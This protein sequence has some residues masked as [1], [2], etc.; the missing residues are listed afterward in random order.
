MQTVSWYVKRL[1]AMSADE[2]AWRARSAA[3]DLTDRARIPLKLY[4]SV[5]LTVSEARGPA[6]LQLCAVPTGAWLSLAPG[7]PAVQWRARLTARAD[8][9]ATHRLSWFDLHDV[10]LGDPIDWNRE[11]ACGRSTPKTL[12]QSIDY[13]DFTVTGDAKVSW[14]PSRHHQLVV[15]GRA[16]RATGRREYASAVVE[17][18]DSW[19]AQCPFGYGMQWRSPLELAIRVINWTWAIDL[20]ADSGALNEAFQTR[21]MQSVMLHVWD[22]ARKYSRGSSANNHRIG[23][24]CGVFAAASYFPTLPG[25]AAL[26]DE[27]FA[28]LS[29]EIGAQ[30]YESGAT[31]EQVIAERLFA[32]QFFLAAGVVARRSGRDFAPAYWSRL[33]RMFAFVRALAEGG[34]PPLSGDGD[35]GYVLDLGDSVSDLESV[36][37][38]ETAL[39]GGEAVSGHAP[40][41]ESVY[42]LLGDSNGLGVSNVARLPAARALES[43]AFADAGYYLLQWG[44]PD[45][46]DRVSVV[47]DCGELGFGSLAAHGHADALSVMVR[48]GGVDLLVDPGTYDYFSFPAWRQ[49]FRSTRAHNTVTIDGRDQSDQ[50]GS[51]LWGRRANARC[52]AWKPRDG[53]GRVDGEHDGYAGLADTV[54]CRR[55]IDLDRDS[56]TLTITDEI[57]ARDIHEIALHFH[58]ADHCEARADGADSHLVDIRFRAGRARLRLDPSLMVTLTKGADA[59]EGGWMS[60]GYHRRTPATIVSGTI[61][62]KGPITLKTRLEFVE[63]RD[64][65]RQA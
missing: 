22:I 50:L 63:L 4:P 39:F 62:S 59:P 20:I 1:Q 53:G 6:P 26:R 49:Y 34:P 60:R 13:R 38:M 3:R 24:A 58:L 11:F 51:F 21:L 29:A 14:E 35:D 30:T 31:R 33:Q 17:Q 54:T 37:Q 56:R 47:F 15:L 65:D 10:D 12:S 5:V 64:S 43:T 41:A 57:A 52:L 9:I 7:D 36:M 19:I 16:Y 25:A 18:I 46:A 44:T 27:S 23:E 61:R 2:M 48:A 42:W 40:R 32:L 55:A 45:S 8:R 28:I